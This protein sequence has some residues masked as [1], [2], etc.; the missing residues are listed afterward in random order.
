M[1]VD[2]AAFQSGQNPL[3]MA[4]QGFSDA[5]AIQQAQQ[6]QQIGAQTLELNRMKVA[7]YQKAQAKQQEFQSALANLGDKP[8]LQD[9]EN[10]M[11]RFP[12]LSSAVKEPYDRLNTRQQ[13]SAF[14]S[15][16]QVMAALKGGKND[17]AKSLL[18]RQA[19]A[20]EN[21][22]NDAAAAGARV[23]MQQ[24]DMEPSAALNAAAL[25]VAAVAGPER[26]ATIYESISKVGRENE[27]QSGALAKQ[28]AEIAKL[29]SDMNI[30]VLSEVRQGAA[31]GID[32][33]QL[34]ANDSE[35]KK[36]LQQLA[37]MS[38]RTNATKDA[39][40]REKLQLEIASKKEEY[41]TKLRERQNEVATSMAN[42]DLVENTIK[43]LEDLGSIS[44]IGGGDM[45]TVFDAATGPL[46]SKMFTIDPDVANFEET[47]NT[48][49]SQVFL[50]QVSKMKGLGALGVA[51]G[52]K[53]MRGL[54]SLSLRQT[55]KQLRLVF[56][57]IRESLDILRELAAKKGGAGLA[58][59][60][61]NI[62]NPPISAVPDQQI[63]DSADAII[64]GN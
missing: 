8:S 10:I 17:E 57:Q 39:D 47:L 3:Q 38:K 45:Y 33:T 34:I 58:Q 32:L 41:Q 56:K 52:E 35:L 7:E 22:G 23:M 49:T 46:Q 19:V 20:A 44:K 5:G 48:L 6:Q 12:V 13:Q 51:E 9:Y 26:F 37:V 31:A 24:I 59:Q 18:E 29:I 62:D 40:E 55:P 60:I 4:M 42:I 64:M 61:E 36:P 30:N 21:S 54:G 63:Y 27:L 1:A 50:S 53:L 43:Q 11:A 14:T 28:E 2:Y 15:A 16:V 25:N